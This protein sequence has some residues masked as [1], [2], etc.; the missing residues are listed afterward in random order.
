[1]VTVPRGAAGTYNWNTVLQIDI[2]ADPAFIS[3]GVITGFQPVILQE[4]IQLVTV[5]G[6]HTTNAT[7]Y[8]SANTAA[9]NES[10]DIDIREQGAL[11]GQNGE[12]VVGKRFDVT[13]ALR[14]AP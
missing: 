12:Q 8:P 6:F 9:T 11:Q 13:Y 5:T 7:C 4:G 2:F 14:C 1:M 3:P 10:L